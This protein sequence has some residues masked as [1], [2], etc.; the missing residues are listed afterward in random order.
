[1]SRQP[2]SVS[3][4]LG[5]PNCAREA[6]RKVSL[7]NN[8]KRDG[9]TVQLMNRDN[10]PEVQPLAPARDD[11]RS[12]PGDEPAD[13]LGDSLERGGNSLM[14]RREPT[15]KQFTLTHVKEKKVLMK[16]V[17]LIVGFIVAV[18]LGFGVPARGAE[19]VEYDVTTMSVGF[20]TSFMA[21][22]GNERIQIVD[23]GVQPE[24]MPRWYTGSLGEAYIWE[25][26]GGGG[27]S[28]LEVFGGGCGSIQMST[29]LGL[30]MPVSQ[31]VQVTRADAGGDFAWIAGYR[32]D[33]TVDPYAA[34]CLK[35]ARQHGA[36]AE[37]VSIGRRVYV[38]P[39]TLKVFITQPKATATVGGTAWIVLWVEGTSG[40]SNTFTLGADGTQV[41]TRT[42]TVRGPVSIPWPTTALPNGTHTLTGTVR[43][44]TGNTG[45]TSITVLVNN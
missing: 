34:F 25:V 15:C 45:T 5:P 27:G 43:D 1:M 12:L 18:V 20:L 38:V 17:G 7:L 9:R 10:S 32:P 21:M 22:A 37:Q 39:S 16:T 8:V 36:Y 14:L 6:K 35:W 31:G 44:A 13:R 3:R 41:A 26:G 30:P 28:A 19:V 42:T 4:I 2:R 29:I 33:G 23:N 11:A 24:G 40:A